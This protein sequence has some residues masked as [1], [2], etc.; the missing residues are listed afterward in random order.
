MDDTYAWVM[1]IPILSVATR[2]MK[3]ATGRSPGKALKTKFARLGTLRGRTK[4]EII[5]A[6][7]S[8]SSISAIKEDVTLLQWQVSGYHIALHFTGDRCNGVTNEHLHH[9]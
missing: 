1:G 9:G 6:V 8:P 5:A 4:D 7:G 3:K 2:A